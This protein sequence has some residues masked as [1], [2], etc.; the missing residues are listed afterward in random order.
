MSAS[1]VETVQAA[2]T[3]G[4]PFTRLVRT[5][6]RKLTDTRAGRWLLAAM[7]ATT[8]LVAAIMLLV[9][10]PKYLTYARFVDFTSTP[11]KL[12]L[13]VLGILT[14]TSEWSQR[15]GLV[16]FTLEP[17]RTRVLLAKVSAALLLSVV[18]FT[19]TV[20]SA[21]AGNLLGP[22]LRHGDGSWAF[23]LAG[24]RDIAVV[25]LTNLAQGLAYGMLLLISAAAIVAYYL[26]PNLSGAL[27]GGVPA[28]KDA[29]RWLDLTQAQ[30]QLYDH[31]M[32]GQQWAQVL[33][34]T[35]IW[36]AVPAAFGVRRVRHTEITST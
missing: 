4:V 20:A 33:T 8:P 18:M 16:T 9:A 28:L 12:L 31:R 36:V 23:G 21:T 11:Q 32:T 34:A 10:D 2:E 29:G 1:T 19:V 7:V 15:T 24:F 5:E 30:G 13:P 26:L 17:N 35:L 14:I 27:F 6:L 22:A 25:L 3:D